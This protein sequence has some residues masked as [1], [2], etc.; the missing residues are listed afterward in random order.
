V[1]PG[2]YQLQLVTGDFEAHEGERID[3]GAAFRVEPGKT[4]AG[5]FEMHEE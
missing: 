1:L 2:S 3:V 5:S 4:H